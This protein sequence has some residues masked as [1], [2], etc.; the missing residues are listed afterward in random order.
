MKTTASTAFPIAAKYALDSAIS[1]S[2]FKN[3]RWE[4]FMF[5]QLAR[6]RIRRFIEV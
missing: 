1:A 6:H 2:R 3:A 5:E 4:F